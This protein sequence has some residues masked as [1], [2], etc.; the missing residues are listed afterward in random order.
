MVMTYQTRE[1]DMVDDICW[2]YYERVDVVIDVLDANPG[3][4]EYGAILPKGIM[5][6]LPEIEIGEAIE[7]IG[8][9]D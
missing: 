2:R 9:W 4:A 7:S 8:L 1:G 5:I 6:L 3:L